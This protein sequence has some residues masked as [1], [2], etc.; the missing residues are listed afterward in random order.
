MKNEI[1]VITLVIK[2]L[3][4]PIQILQLDEEIFNKV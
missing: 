2:N 1:S 3:N 4:E